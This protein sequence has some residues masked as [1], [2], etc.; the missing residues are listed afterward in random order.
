MKRIFLAAGVLA[1]CAGAIAAVQRWR[2]GDGEKVFIPAVENL[3]VPRGPGS[4]VGARALGKVEAASEEIGVS[5]DITGRIAEIL[6]DEGDVVEKGA[7]LVRLEPFVYAS[8]P[9]AL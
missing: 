2:N 4:G 8:R 3:P 1:L 6:V 5:S 7:P 9:I